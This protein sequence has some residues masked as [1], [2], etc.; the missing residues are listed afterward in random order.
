MVGI[1]WAKQTAGTRSNHI[2]TLAFRVAST[3][4]HPYTSSLWFL[5]G[6]GERLANV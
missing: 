4:T 3:N 6:V 5:F 1:A 2:G